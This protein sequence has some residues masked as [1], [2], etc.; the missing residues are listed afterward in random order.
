MKCRRINRYRKIS[1]ATNLPITV[2]VMEVF[3]ATAE[4][5]ADLQVTMGER[6]KVN[7]DTGLPLIFSTSFEGTIADVVKTQEYVTN[8]ITKAR[9]LKPAYKVMAG[10]DL[11]LKR[12]VIE[13]S[14]RVINSVGSILPSAPVSKEATSGI[15]EE[16]ASF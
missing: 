4:Q 8:P 3:Q 9:E 6:F 14:A 11:E 1:K 12:S 15:S 10:E 2:H 16:D 5:L 7:P 13:D